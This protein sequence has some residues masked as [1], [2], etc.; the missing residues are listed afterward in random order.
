MMNIVDC[1][2]KIDEINS[3]L[4]V[5]FDNN[6]I[7]FFPKTNVIKPNFSNQELSFL[8]LVSWLYTIYVEVGKLS[9]S[10]IIKSMTTEEQLKFK[11]HKTIVQNYRTILQHNIDISS[12]TRDFK[13][14]KDCCTWAKKTCGKNI[15]NTEADWAKMSEAMMNETNEIL[16]SILRTL[17]EM[18]NSDLKK[19][20]FVSNW[21]ATVNKN[22]S[23][24]EFDN[25]IKKIINFIDVNDFDIVSYRNK[26]LD[27]WR[28][29]IYTLNSSANYTFEIKKIVESSIIKDFIH[30]IPFT[31][32]EIESKFYLSKEI[33]RHIY[34]YLD[35]KLLSSE[36][37]SDDILDEM[38]E[39]FKEY[40]KTC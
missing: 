10:T 16:S 23:P 9:L 32:D 30:V 2:R 3:V 17:E 14:S 19:Q 34:E 21:E 11:D 35:E 29:Y 18:T 25:H 40:K 33:F 27:N 15:P 4:A 26:N 39:K 28:R 31:I 22:I 37:C 7:L 13:L 6:S 38:L 24:Y 36:D 5:L 20:I 12:S 1:E 8:R